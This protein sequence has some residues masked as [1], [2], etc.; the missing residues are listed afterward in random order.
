M[1]REKERKRRGAGGWITE[2]K[3]RG[4]GRERERNK[5][6]CTDELTPASTRHDGSMYT[7]LKPG[8][9]LL[10]ALGDHVL[11]AVNI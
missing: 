7:E 10:V 4:G 9:F 8:G 3:E 1:E 2:R 11:L 5:H 6:A